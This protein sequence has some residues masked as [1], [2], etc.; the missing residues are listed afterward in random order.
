MTTDVR[1][2][3]A[4]SPTGSPH[5][6]NIRSALFTWLYARHTGGKF[7]LRVED[8][9]QKRE[10]AT[11][12]QDIL[13][14]LSWLG[15]NWD[16]GPD[17]GGPY[18]PYIQSQRL[19]LYQKYAQQL[20]D[21]GH[22]YRCYCTPERLTALRQEQIKRKDSHV[23]YDR[24]CRFLSDAE[25]AELEASGAPSV[26]RL[27]VPL[28]GQTSFHDLIHGDIAIDNALVDDQVLLKTD[29]FPTYHLAVVVDDH[30]MR[31]SHVT[32]G[33][34]WLPSAPKHIL[35]YDAFGWTPPVFCHLPRVLGPDHKKLGKRHGA[36]SVLAFR[37]M[38][39]LPEAL[40]NFLALVGWSYDDQTEIF[41]REEL[42]RVFSLDK[43][44]AGP[45][46]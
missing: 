44:S 1:V 40:L 4:P 11:G 3:F 12:L 42:I 6:G 22:A 26:I 23:G 39:Y 25:R 20:L 36:T 21:S 14:S 15:L 7:I 30:H 32:R 18:G 28:E 27:A 33:E 2:R 17:V 37:D 13:D 43:I 19:E 46:R 38:G 45:G 41:S 10:S 24:H 34:E 31:I 5:V 16:E 35:L 8:T 9:D 29:G